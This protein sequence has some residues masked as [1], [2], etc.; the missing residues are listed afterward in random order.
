LKGGVRGIAWWLKL[1]W[2]RRRGDWEGVGVCWA[3]G[4]DGAPQGWGLKG[5]CR[6]LVCD[7]AFR[8]KFLKLGRLCTPACH[9]E[10]ADGVRATDTQ[11]S[12]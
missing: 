4:N 12:Q 5:W 2:E 3:A 9:A 8:E 11:L 1:E 6:G 10:Y 7:C